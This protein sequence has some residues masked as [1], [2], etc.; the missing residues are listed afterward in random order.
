LFA[1]SEARRMPTREELV[2]NAATKTPEQAHDPANPKVFFDIR[3]G[4]PPA[5]RVTFEVM[6]HVFS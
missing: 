3:I 1:N 5:G 2:K 6:L 4:D